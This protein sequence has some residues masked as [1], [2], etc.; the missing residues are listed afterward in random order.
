MCGVVNGLPLCDLA[1]SSRPIKKSRAIILA[2]VPA[3]VSFV[4]VTVLVT[5]QCKKK[6]PKAEIANE[7]LEL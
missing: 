7:V 4:F 3:F 2:I 6:K 5:W 1:R